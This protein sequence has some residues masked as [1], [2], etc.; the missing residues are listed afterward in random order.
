MITL[1]TSLLEQQYVRYNALQMH[2]LGKSMAAIPRSE[3]DKLKA[4]AAEYIK[5]KR[6]LKKHYE[7]TL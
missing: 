1:T 5:L 4:K 2:Y 3:S 7:N 6:E